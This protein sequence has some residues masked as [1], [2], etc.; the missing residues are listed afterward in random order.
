VTANHL[1]GG[2][3]ESVAKTR[4]ARLRR[5]TCLWTTSR[6]SGRPTK[7]P[8]TGSRGV[9]AAAAKAGHPLAGTGA[10]V[11]TAIYDHAL[12]VGFGRGLQVSAG[13]MLIALII[14]IA[15]VRVRRAD[16]AGAQTTPGTPAA[17]EASAEM[18]EPANPA[19]PGPAA[20]DL[21]LMT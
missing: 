20:D 7:S 3:P 16:L 18:A 1:P 15:A 4:T 11:K 9:A 6:S 14:T 12:S 21:R 17:D 8:K 5:S 2:K 19:G 10:Q 13:I